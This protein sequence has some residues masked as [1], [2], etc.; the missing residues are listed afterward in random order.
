MK[1]DEKLV[2][3]ADYYGLEKQ[4]IKLE[5]E[6]SE[7]TMALATKDDIELAQELVDVIVMAEQVISLS[8]QEELAKSTRQFKLDRQIAR[9]KQEEK[10][11]KY[12]TVPQ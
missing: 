2:R 1:L 7:V 8:N 6:L 3:I 5:E 4:K 10:A 11:E 9:I 12:P